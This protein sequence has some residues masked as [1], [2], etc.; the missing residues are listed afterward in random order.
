[1]KTEQMSPNEESH[2][3]INIMIATCLKIKKIISQDNY[4]IAIYRY[5]IEVPCEFF[6]DF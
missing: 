3:M 1:M 4:L 6:L 2:K 5:G